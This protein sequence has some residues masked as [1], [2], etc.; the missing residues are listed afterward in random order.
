MATV[1]VLG[2]QWENTNRARGDYD[3]RLS[4]EKGEIDNLG[5]DHPQFRFTH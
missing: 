3:W 5:D 4:L 1:M 2:L